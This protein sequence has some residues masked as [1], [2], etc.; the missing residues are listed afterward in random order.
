M[1]PR[2]PSHF[3]RLL[4]LCCLAIATTLAAAQPAPPAS[5]ALPEATIRVF[6]RDVAVLRG[7]LLG[8]TPE[9][10]ARRAEQRIDEHLA[11][12]PN[13]VVNSEAN[14]LGTII[15]L[16]DEMVFILTPGDVDFLTRQSMAE[17]VAETSVR[18]RHL[19]RDS[20][21]SRDTQSLLRGLAI[22]ATATLALIVVI[23]L[24]ARIRRTI[25]RRLLS[26][27]ETKPLAVAG[28]ELVSQAGLLGFL[29]KLSRLFFYVLAAILIYLW[30]SLCLAQFP[31]TRPWGVGLNGYLMD[32]ATAFG[33]AILHAIP[34]LLTA[35]AIFFL[36]YWLTKLSKGFF[37]QIA[38]R[39]GQSGFLDADL[40]EPSHKI[41]SA[42]IWLF[43]LAM[44]YPYLPGSDSE[45]FKGLS[46]LVGL[47]L[48]LG[49]SS[50]VSQ[51]ASG[52]ILTYSRT[53]RVGEYVR[54]G[55]V[56]GTVTYLGIFNTRIRTGMGEELTLANSTVFSTTTR[57]YS[58]A[59]NAGGYILDTTVTIGY[60]TPWR[61]VEA[62]LLEAADNTHGLCADPAP[63]VYQTALSD[64]YPE[65]RLVCHAISGQ[66][67][68][69]AQALNDLHANIQD[70]FNRY[71]VQIM[72]PHYVLDPNTEKLVPED[73][74]YAM[75]AKKPD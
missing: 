58:R 1:S 51:G 34:D 59:S 32:S 22:T 31:Y 60:D 28:V 27:A 35:A 18:L 20:R 19:V 69:R 26:L 74:K 70:A 3:I 39:R 73:R 14:P 50:I 8:A 30:L 37:N 17:A 38:S 23:W 67:R 65:Y 24:A 52:L 75:P 21:E 64:F 13:A 43:A 11:R 25:A 42:V 44:S 62:M 68:N 16:D 29:L 45:A 54:I 6:N 56:E 4:A 61:Q 72:S 41:I 63:R 2:R 36:A 71:G 66:P 33:I 47:M 10:R 49:A 55:D 7:K 53:F 57:N 48:S 40:A 9:Q 15:K 5:E 46:V 12:F